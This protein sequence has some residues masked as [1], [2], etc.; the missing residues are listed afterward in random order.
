MARNNKQKTK[1]GFR[2]RQRA[3]VMNIMQFQRGPDHRWHFFGQQPDEI[4]RLIVRKHWWFLVQPAL[5]LLGAIVL[6]C[7]FLVGTASIPSV[8]SL[9]YV[10][11]I[12][13]VGLIILTGIRFL[14][15]DLVSWW[16]ETHIITNKRIIDTRGLLEPSR[17]FTALDK[18]QQVGTGVDT[19]LGFLLGFGTVYIYL[20]GSTVKLQDVPNIKH[21]RDALQGVTHEIKGKKKAEPPAKQ[22][23]NKE[24][25][26]VI[27]T[28]AK[29]VPVPTLPKVDDDL[30]P[31]RNE[32]RF[33]GPRRTFGGPLRIRA[34]L[35]YLA[36]EYTVKYVQ[37][38]RYILWRNLSLPLLGLIV[39]LAV[40][41]IPP[42]LG[43][44]SGPIQQYWWLIMSIIVLALLITAGLIFANYID[45]VY[46]LT[47]QRI[48]DINRK[49]I[50]FFENRLEAEFKNVRDV[51][52]KIPNLIERFLD[53][54]NI[55]VETQ[56]SN[57]PDII[58]SNVDH[59]FT[60]QDE[61][62]GIK[63]HKE[64]ED[65]AKKENAEKEHLKKWFDTVFIKLEET[66]KQVP[67]LRE[68]YILTAME[69]AQKHGL[70]V[71]ISPKAEILPAKPPGFVIDQNPLPGTMMAKDGKI[72]VV[73]SK[74]R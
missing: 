12:A 1:S 49:F 43:A 25:A 18:V 50:F 26:G 13:A 67:D 20:S 32:S 48:I 54:G 64:K 42:A 65:K 31:L 19:F 28:L 58:L 74:K 16:F 66:A 23:E 46:I 7:L 44:M 70:K 57:N 56:G 2:I 68:Q 34:D 4:V 39:A 3:S 69:L 36:G 38:S 15:K 71:S 35:H 59:P 53:I 63:G 14:Y 51:K 24:I 73:L 60:L 9:W 30:P 62:Q 21:I 61:I 29:K 22:P 40:M 47:N 33:L 17:Q 55:S 8:G 11:D 10:L 41:F 6:L 72:E 52:V 5:P 45:D 37:R 27:D